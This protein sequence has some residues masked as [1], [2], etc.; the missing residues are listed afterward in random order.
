MPAPERPRFHQHGGALAA[1]IAV[2]ADHL[3]GVGDHQLEARPAAPGDPQRGR[4]RRQ[5]ERA[6]LA[7]EL[8]L[9][10]E[11]RGARPPGVPQP[12]QAAPRRTAPPQA[13]RVVA[14]MP[15][16][17][18]EADLLRDRDAVPLGPVALQVV[19]AR[20]QVDQAVAVP[21][22]R[23]DLHDPARPDPQVGPDPQLAA[24]AEF[25]L[26]RHPRV[27][28]VD[29][30]SGVERHQVEPRLGAVGDRAETSQPVEALDG[31]A[32][33][34]PRGRAGLGGHRPVD[35]RRAALGAPAGRHE[36]GGRAVAEP[37]HHR[38]L[39]VPPEPERSRARRGVP[40]EPG[41]RVLPGRLDALGLRLQVNRCH[42][43]LPPLRD[44]EATPM[45]RARIVAGR[46]GRGASRP[47]VS[48]RPRSVARAGR[49]SPAIPR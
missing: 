29:E 47:A 43:R 46:G 13:A 18:V 28:Q 15:P 41:P 9:E 5:L 23:D 49:F 11:R 19:D 44:C 35:P 45:P 48:P 6:L 39:G 17:L 36:Q 12:E 32:G 3:A 20:Q 4:V 21:V 27:G 30:P 31:R 33:I 14:G 25:R 7:A 37:V 26:G 34:E 8:R 24:G 40:R 38:R 16:L 2:D 22:D 1:E 42:R 10:L